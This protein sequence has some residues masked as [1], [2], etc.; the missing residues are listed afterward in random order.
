MEYRAFEHGQPVQ[1]SDLKSFRKD[2][3]RQAFMVD[4]K[5]SFAGGRFHST[6]SLGDGGD[7]GHYWSSSPYGSADPRNA[8]TLFLNS[9]Y[10]ID[11]DN[12]RSS[13]YSVRCFKD[14]DP[15]NNPSTFTLTFDSKGGD[16][17]DSVTIES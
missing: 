12:K 15:V 16:A 8:L 11:N 3:N 9:S 17:V 7:Y 5:L 13:G 14:Y 10:V 2:T 4:M 1:G 6:A